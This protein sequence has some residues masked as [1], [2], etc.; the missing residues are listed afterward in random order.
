MARVSD[1]SGKKSN[2]QRSGRHKSGKSRSGTRAFAPR[3]PH[4]LHGV[5]KLKVQRLNL[6]TVK[7][8]FGKIKMTMKEYKTYFRNNMGKIELVRP[9]PVE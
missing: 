2:I 7:T 9:I 5:K 6:R 8:P 3:G 4:G 1:I